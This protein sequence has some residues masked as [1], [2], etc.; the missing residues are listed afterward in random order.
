MKEDTHIN[1][2]FDDVDNESGTIILIKTINGEQACDR[3]VTCSP[4]IFIVLRRFIYSQRFPVFRQC[5][6][7]GY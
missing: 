2:L 4:F 6:L 3:C 7:G 1:T 5:M